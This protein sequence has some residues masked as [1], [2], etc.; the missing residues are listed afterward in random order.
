MRYYYIVCLIL[1]ILLLCGIAAAL[2][3]LNRDK[4]N[5]IALPKYYLIVGIVCACTFPIALYLAKDSAPHVVLFSAALLVSLWIILWHL[6]GRIYYDDT[7][8]TVKGFFGTR[9]TYSYQEIE[10]IR[11]ERK[12]VN[13]Y[14]GKQ[15]ITI[16]EYA[17]KKE[18][19]LIL[20]EAQYRK[21][22][23]GNAIPQR[24]QYKKDIFLGHVENPEEFI[25]AYALI[26][27][28]IIGCLIASFVFAKEA[29]AADFEPITV[30]PDSCEIVLGDLRLYEKDDP[31]YY[32]IQNYAKYME[33]PE[34]VPALF[35]K[36]KSFQ[37]LAK[38]Y[39]DKR[40]SYFVVAALT[41][42][43]GTA[44]YTLEMYNQNYMENLRILRIAL[45]IFGIVWG[46]FIALSVYV[47]RHPEKF[48][49][50]FIRL[51]FKDGYVR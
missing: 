17:P 37:V 48:S 25:F 41:G 26:S 3:S 43:D 16:N 50:K 4:R 18:E 6:N 10:Y 24:S 23:N 32:S 29:T 20:A 39:E 22:H 36:N 1:F 47:G 27:V 13:L 38:Y 28:L 15:V 35:E 34:G 7:E 2:V 30:S 33:D 49:K 21:Y 44:Y 42:E 12:D 14:I 5:C 31:T 45:G 40:E 51:F 8:F 19:F 9:R 46:G 11:G